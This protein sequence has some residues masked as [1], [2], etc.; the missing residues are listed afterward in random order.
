MKYNTLE[1]RNFLVNN[2]SECES[3]AIFPPSKG[4]RN[5]INCNIILHNLLFL[6]YR[7]FT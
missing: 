4:E 5:E 3:G 7:Y 6:F 2:S 1:N